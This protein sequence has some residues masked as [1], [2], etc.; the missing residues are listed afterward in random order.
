MLENLTSWTQ[1]IESVTQVS[2][3]FQ[4]WPLGGITCIGC[5]FGHL[6]RFQILSPQNGSKFYHQVAPLALVANLASSHL[7]CHVVK[8][9]TDSS[10]SIEF[11]SSSAKSQ[12]Y[13][14]VEAR[15]LS[16]A[17]NIANS[18]VA[19]FY[20]YSFE[21]CLFYAVTARKKRGKKLAKNKQSNFSCVNIEIVASA[22]WHPFAMIHVFHRFPFLHSSHIGVMSVWLRHPCC[23][24]KCCGCRVRMTCAPA[25]A[26]SWKRSGGSQGGGMD[27]EHSDDATLL[28]VRV[29]PH[30]PATACVGPARDLR[31]HLNAAA[32]P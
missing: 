32:C 3:W 5:K 11:V 10:V 17:N 30:H 7:H 12:M 21:I 29:R 9:I 2:H 27:T 8:I 16:F 13:H 19:K 1:A 24:C 14:S 18:L 26:R 20:V 31:R 22:R 15:H 23:F 28:S 25:D 6:K 4:S